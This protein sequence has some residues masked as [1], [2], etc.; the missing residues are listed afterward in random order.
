MAAAKAV[1][2][3]RATSRSSGGPPPPPPRPDRRVDQHPPPPF[4]LVGSFGSPAGV[5]AGRGRTRRPPVGRSSTSTATAARCPGSPRSASL[6]G[7]RVL[8]PGLARPAHHR[9][10]RPTPAPGR[11]WRPWPRR[12]ST[13]RGRSGW[14]GALRYHGRRA[15]TVR[16]PMSVSSSHRM[17]R[18]RWNAWPS[19]R[20]GT[21]PA[22][23]RRS[24]R[25]S[26]PA[27]PPQRWTSTTTGWAGGS[28]PAPSSPSRGSS[29]Q[30]SYRNSRLCDHPHAVLGVVDLVGVGHQAPHDVDPR[31]VVEL[32]TA[33]RRR[34]GSAR[35]ASGGRG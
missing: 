28:S 22:R 7:H 1:A 4:C 2:A 6:L 9:G 24:G 14:P 15:P 30:R 12:R 34:R 16:M 32:E 8:P 25:G 27:T 26:A 29:T 19:R 11:G 31:G 3:R 23:S 18:S 35:P 17:S 13:T 5:G 10:G 33:R 20:P 21:A